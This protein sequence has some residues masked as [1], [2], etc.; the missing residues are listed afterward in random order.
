MNY[1]LYPRFKRV[2]ITG[3]AGFIGSNFILRILNIK[4]LA[5]LNIDKISY[6]SDID[7]IKSLNN[8]KKN[9]NFLKVDLKNHIHIQE[10]IKNFKP[11]LIVNFAAESH[12]DRSIKY[13]REF[14]E[15]N[16]IGTF[17]LLEA[18]K[19]YWEKLSLI[20]KEKFRFL[21]ISTD[22]VF[23]TLKK[24]GQFSEKSPYN[25]SSP[26]SASKAASDHFVRAWYK[27][28]GLPILISNCSNNFGPFQFPEKL[29]PLMI[30]KCINRKSLPVYG[31][32]KNIRDWIFV[33]DHC[34]AIDLILNE[35]N[36]GETYLIG[37]NNEKSNM[38]IVNLICSYFNN[39]IHNKDNFDYF[40]LIASMAKPG[41]FP[42]RPLTMIVPYGPGGGSGQVA[43][44]MAKAVT[45]LTGVD[46]N[47]DHKPGG[48]GT[49]GMT[50]YMAMPTDGYNV[51]EHIDDASSAHALDS[52]KPHPGK[53][54]IPLVISQVTFSQ[55]YIRTNENL[56]TE[57]K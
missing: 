2:L 46:I 12:V 8:N 9:Y 56:Y 11:D 29:I 25:P 18:S 13:P 40:S 10:I 51:L 54:L 21:Q 30:I 24:T 3:G 32:G 17:N 52:S 1:S 48:S 27:T 50:A 45:E 15:S 55:I 33:E 14:L 44:G 22:E 41:G 4:E 20:E 34:M 37:A 38:D 42:D 43:A 19:S 6:A 16:T 36:L 26:Y 53:D 5:L 31:D 57:W 23:G 7:F 49:V 35:G 28:Y 39:S 47:R